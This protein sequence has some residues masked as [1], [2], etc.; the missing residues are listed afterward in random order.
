MP[1]SSVAVPETGP[2]TTRELAV[3]SLLRQGKANKII[4]YELGISENTAKVH[5]RN[6]LRK[7]GATNRTQAIYKS[8]QL[9]RGEAV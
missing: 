6:I 3:L 5:I 2:L 9:L 1:E 7:V 4:A 8:S